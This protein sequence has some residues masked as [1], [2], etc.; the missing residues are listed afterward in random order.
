MESGLYKELVDKNYLIPHRETEEIKPEGNGWKIIKPEAIP[1]ISYSYEWPFSMLKDAAILTLEIQR[2]AL[3]HGMSLKDASAFNIQIFNGK[4]ILIDTLSFEKYE[5]GKPWVA[6]KQF[7][8]HFLTPLTLMSYDDVRLGRISSVFLDGIPVDLAASMLPLSAKFKPKLLF[9]IFAHASTQKRYSN[10]KMDASQKNKVFSK[11]ALIGLIDSLEG[12]IKGLRFDPKGT[13]WEDYYEENN[14]YTSSSHKDKADL[15]E[16]Y[17]KKVRPKMVWDMGANTGM[18]SSIASKISDQVIAFDIDY[19]A[20]EKGY[21][22]IKKNNIKNVIPLFCDFTNPINSTGWENEERMSLVQ[23]GPADCILA[24][25]IVHHLAIPHN[26]PFEK[27]ASG[28]SKIGKNIIVE[29]IEKE[30]SQVQ[31]LLA[32]RKDIFDSYTEEDFEKAF[33][34]YFNIREKTKIKDT[35]RTLYLMERKN[36]K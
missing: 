28:F 24:L 27:I 29:F 35:K 34:I 8:E 15:V 36:V 2:I 22:S 17:L 31:I 4:P 13:E 32:S 26:L 3:K 11:R 25:A 19:G 23:R 30:D 6:Y 7:V 12:S 18:F 21:Q 20:L 9:H 14:N 1:F 5:E 10:K 16:R 33:G